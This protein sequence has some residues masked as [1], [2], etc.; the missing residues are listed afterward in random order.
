L[1]LDEDNY[2]E[3]NNENSRSLYALNTQDLRG[4]KDDCNH[5]YEYSQNYNHSVKSNNMSKGN[6]EATNE[7]I[8]NT[9]YH[10]FVNNS[11][12]NTLKSLSNLNMTTKVEFQ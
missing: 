1:S 11:K 9:K 6:Y 7:S 2:N 8:N 5:Q 10:S 3:D 4:I 12:N